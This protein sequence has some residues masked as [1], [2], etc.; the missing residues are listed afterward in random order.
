MAKK[1]EPIEI[2]YPFD[3]AEISLRRIAGAL[4]KIA[5]LQSM[6]NAIQLQNLEV[7]RRMAKIMEQGG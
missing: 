7:S 2:H 6:N 5:E 1:K 3:E 4:E